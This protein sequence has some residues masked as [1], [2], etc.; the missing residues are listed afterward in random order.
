MVKIVLEKIVYSKKVVALS[1]LL[2]LIIILMATMLTPSYSRELFL[3]ILGWL[4]FPFL[5]YA[6]WRKR[7]LV[8]LEDD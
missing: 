1:L 3:V 4:V 8:K 5:I 2:A 6:W 7:K